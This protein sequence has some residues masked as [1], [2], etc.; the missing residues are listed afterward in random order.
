MNTSML[1]RLRNGQSFS[2]CVNM[3]MNMSEATSSAHSASA[4]TTCTSNTRIRRPGSNSSRCAAVKMKGEKTPHMTMLW[5]V[6][7]ISVGCRLR[8]VGQV[9]L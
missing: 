4:N 5:M 9:A 2:R 3:L 6:S 1:K 8:A 7:R